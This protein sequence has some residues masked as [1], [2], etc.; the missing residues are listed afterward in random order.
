MSSDNPAATRSQI[1]FMNGLLNISLNAQTVIVRSKTFVEPIP[2]T[3]RVADD[4]EQC[5]SRRTTNTSIK[6][7]QTLKLIGHG[8]VSHNALFRI[9]QPHSIILSYSGNSSK[10]LHCVYVVYIATIEG[11]SVTTAHRDTWQ[12]E[13]SSCRLVDRFS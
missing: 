1:V 13:G 2:I 6:T 11:K 5:V 10:I 7:V 8:N 9:A 3:R 12:V 4:S